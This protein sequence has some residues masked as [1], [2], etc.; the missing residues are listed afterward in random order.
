MINALDEIKNDFIIYATEVNNNRAFPDARD[1]LKISQRAV[2]WEMYDKKYSSIKPH[3]KCAKVDGGVIANWHPHGSE[4]STLVRMSQP[5]IN[6]ICEV[7]FHGGNG[8]LQGGPDA[9][10][11]R[12]TEC[13]L[14]KASEDGFFENIKNDSVDMILNFSED[15]KWPSVFP[16]V[17]PRLFINGSQGIGYTIAQEWEP[18]NL[19]EFT[20]KVKNYIKNGKVTTDNIYPDYP[21]GGV[22][23]NK[24]DIHTIYDSG[25]GTVILR[26]KVDINDNIIKITE[27]P[28]QVYAEPLIAKI[29]ELVNSE[30]LTGI[31]DIYNKSDENGLLIEIEC[32][33]DANVVVNKLYKLT[34]L[35]CSFSANQMAL[36]NGVPK[37]LPLKEYIKVYVDHNIECIIREHKYILDKSTQRYEV[38]SGLVKA[39]SD[40]DNIVELIKKS[41]SSE[42]AKK[43]LVKTKGFTEIQAQ[44]V[45]DMKLGKLAN[46]EKDELKKELDELTKVIDECNDIIGSKDKQNEVFIKRL[47]DFT[48]KYGWKRRTEVTDVDIVKEKAIVKASSKKTSEQFMVVLTKGN[49]I[50]RVSLVNYKPQTKVKNED[51]KITH[52]IKVGATEKF[53]LIS[54]TGMMYKLQTNK[55]PV[56]TVNAT[57]TSLKDMFNDKIIAIYRGDEEDEFIFMLTQ[58]G[59]VK[60]MFASDVFSI[61]KNKGCSIIKLTDDIVIDVRLIASETVKYEVDGREYK[62]D[63]TKFKTKGRSAGGVK[64]IK[65]KS[66]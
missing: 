24:K 19:D 57:G 8:S 6:N 46:L 50:K 45:V 58:K 26:G 17:F 47:N 11:S 62:V 56:G 32:S 23:I 53:I 28:Y 48:K 31:E 51:D 12:Y 43:Q 66:K 41:K 29:K 27:L 18:G 59:L 33:E 38:V 7:D 10:A 30:Q 1:G 25:K 44:A 63:T 55:I 14:S 64:G 20:N 4:Y 34:D 54:E 65:W 60:K 15:L 13:R 5:W 16:A 42:D 9:S 3:V 22:I 61:G 39:L 35:Q 37:M 2:L 52:V 36:V 49:Y 40:I 21:S